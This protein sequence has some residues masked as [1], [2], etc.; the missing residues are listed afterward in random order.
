MSLGDLLGCAVGQHL[1]VVQSQFYAPTTDSQRGRWALAAHD[2]RQRGMIRSQRGCEGTK[3]V[4]RVAEAAVPEL[5][6]DPG[7]EFLRRHDWGIVSLRGVEDNPGGRET[8][9]VRCPRGGDCVELKD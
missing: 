9:A 7:G 6:V 5:C 4:A 2:L 3:G 8:G 1:L